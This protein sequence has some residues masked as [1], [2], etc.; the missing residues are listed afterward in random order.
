MVLAH[1]LLCSARLFDDVVPLLADDGLELIVPTF[2]DHPGSGVSPRPWE[3]TDLV[4]DLCAVLDE[5]GH[6]HALFAG[7][8]MGGMTA[9][10][11]AMRYPHRVD[12]LAL[13]STSA[14]PER[15]IDRAKFT[16]LAAG[17]RVL[18][19]RKP[20]LGEA[21]RILFH[22]DYIASQPDRVA[23]WRDDVS[24]LAPASVQRA[25]HA[26]AWRADIRAE[27]DD[28]RV[29]AAVLV[30]ADDHATPPRRAREIASLLGC[31]A[32]VEV[33]GVGHST[34]MESP[35]AVADVIRQLVRRVDAA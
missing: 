20:L 24:N 35:E 34:P 12:G 14:A 22:R 1:G 27:L 28:L 26:V 33:P 31:D 32:P 5:L 4:H 21:V 15:R 16:V 19:P 23:A 13:L 3:L 29:P 8:S 9:T 25:V 7:F 11:L 30:G 2:R 18:G 10:R 6:E 17:A